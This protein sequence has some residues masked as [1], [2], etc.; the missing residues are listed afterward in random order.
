MDINYTISDVFAFL[1]SVPLYVWF[2]TLIVVIAIFGDR[3]KWDLDCKFSGTQDSVEAEIEVK[4]YRKKGKFI[5][6]NLNLPA[7]LESKSVQIYIN[8]L[9]ALTVPASKNNGCIRNYKKPYPYDRPTRGSR[10]DVKV[11]LQTLASGSLE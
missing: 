2:I 7:N 8:Q 4:E 1:H 6:V 11:D 5:E 10:V 3:Q 9:L